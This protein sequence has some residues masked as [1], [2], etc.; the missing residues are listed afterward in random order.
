MIKAL[1]AS[2]LIFSSMAFADTKTYTVEGMHCGGCVDA[3]KAKVCKLPDIE[4]CDVNVGSVT[5]TSKGTLNDK[6]VA[7][8]VEAA[9]YKMAAAGS[10]SKVAMSCGGDKEAMSC[11]ANESCACDHH[12][13]KD[14]KKKKK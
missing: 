6:N 2:L 14:S 8:A 10:E 11:G 13:G 9:G 3:V 12:K 1:L 5:L 7:D 4:K